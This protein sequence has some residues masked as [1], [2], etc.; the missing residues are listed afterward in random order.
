MLNPKHFNNLHIYSSY[1]PYLI[2]IVLQAQRLHATHSA[3]DGLNF[4]L[5]R[6]RYRFIY[7][8]YLY[9]PCATLCAT[10][11]NKPDRNKSIYT[12]LSDLFTIICD[13]LLSEKN[14]STQLCHPRA[15]LTQNMH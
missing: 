14:F 1:L 9:Y 4:Q 15:R 2:F 7:V 13:R 3:R 11:E 8:C 12:Q 5:K 10:L 6:R